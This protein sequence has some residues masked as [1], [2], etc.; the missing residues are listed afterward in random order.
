MDSHPGLGRVV[1]V[2]CV[3]SHQRARSAPVDHHPLCNERRLSR[4]LEPAVFQQA[5]PGLGIG[6]RGVFM[7][8]CSSAGDWTLAD[9]PFGS[10]DERPISLVGQLREL[11][12]LD[13]R[14]TERALRGR[15]G[16]IRPYAR[17]PIGVPVASIGFYAIFMAGG[18]NPS[19]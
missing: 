4:T 10:V 12:E 2:H 1:G 19:R 9:F 5:A 8:F 17:L 11:A 16:V 6:R 15:K 18:T 3:G 13:H 14:E 7:G